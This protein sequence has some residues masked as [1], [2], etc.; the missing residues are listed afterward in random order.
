MEHTAPK[1]GDFAE[2]GGGW[3]NSPFE[4]LCNCELAGYPAQ[5]PFCPPVIGCEEEEEEDL[6]SA[7]LAG[8]ATVIA[9]LLAKYGDAV[10]PVPERNAVQIVGCEGRIVVHIPVPEGV[11]ALLAQ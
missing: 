5:H 11:F 1:A 2:Y 8:D 4:G 3:H 7:I 6:E 10:D 9:K